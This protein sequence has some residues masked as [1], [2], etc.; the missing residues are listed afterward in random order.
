M[1]RWTLLFV[2]CAIA[3]SLAACGGGDSS[4]DIE[5][6]TR[7]LRLRTLELSVGEGV[8]GNRPVEVTLVRVLDAKLVSRLLETDTPDWYG[9]EREVFEG[10]APDSIINFWEVVPGTRVGPEDMQIDGKVAGILYCYLLDNPQPPERFERNGEV[11]VTITDEGCRI[12]G[13]TPTRE[14]T[15]VESALGT[16]GEKIGGFFRGLGEI[17]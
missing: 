10:A 8:N 6:P 13:G 2:G 5:E 12:S 11:S 9:G 7:P 4:D 3:A 1:K 15:E 17:F 16:V 14:P